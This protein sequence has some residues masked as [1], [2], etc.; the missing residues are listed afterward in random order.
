MMQIAD[1]CM[2]PLSVSCSA[3][4]SIQCDWWWIHRL[5]LK[6]L[7]FSC[8]LTADEQKG[9]VWVP[10]EVFIYMPWTKC[11]FSD[12]H[13]ARNILYWFKKLRLLGWFISLLSRN[14]IIFNLHNIWVAAY[15]CGASPDFSWEIKMGFRL[16]IFSMCNNLTN[17]CERQIICMFNIRVFELAYRNNN[18]RGKYSKSVP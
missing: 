5:L 13:G 17:L 1:V 4:S 15:I 3:C 11:L 7:R 8:Q 2:R 16:R 12:E 18:I 14:V 10:D 9:L 6:D